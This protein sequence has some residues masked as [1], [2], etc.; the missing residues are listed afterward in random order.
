MLEQIYAA[1]TSGG[2]ERPSP[3]FAQQGPAMRFYVNGGQ[4]EHKL[5]C[6]LYGRR[7]NLF[8]LALLFTSVLTVPPHLIGIRAVFGGSLVV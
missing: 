6:E 5:V 1:V 8:R 7:N 3:D 2:A 4:R